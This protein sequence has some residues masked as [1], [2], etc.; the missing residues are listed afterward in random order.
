[1]HNPTSVV[2]QHEEDV[3]HLETDRRDREEVDGHGRRQ[4][5]VQERAPRLRR[6]PPAA[7]HVLADAGFSNVN[8]EFQQLTVD[9]WCAPQRVLSTHSLN[10]LTEMVR[11]GWASW[12]PV[13]ALPRPEQPEGVAMPRDDGVRLDDDQRRSPVAQMRQSHAQGRKTGAYAGP[14]IEQGRIRHGTQGF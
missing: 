7:T 6:W 13:M 2:C 10:Q 9:A 5:T 14:S 8:A 4:V 12:P 11:N 3:E 1:M